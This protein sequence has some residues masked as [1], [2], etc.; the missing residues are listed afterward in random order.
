MCIMNMS[1]TMPGSAIDSSN[2]LSLTSSS[3][4]KLSPKIANQSEYNPAI[5]ATRICILFYCFSNLLLVYLLYIV[6]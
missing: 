5:L 2:W 1:K 4:T 3:G 6:S